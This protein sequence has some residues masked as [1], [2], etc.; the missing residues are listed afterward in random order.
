[1]PAGRVAPQVNRKTVLLEGELIMAT[2]VEAPLAV[3]LVQIPV[4]L[5]QIPVTLVQI[6]AKGKRSIKRYSTVVG[7]GFGVIQ[8]N[9]LLKMKKRTQE[10]ER[11]AKCP[12]RKTEPE[13]E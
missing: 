9:L 12:I 8:A 11:V 6:Q 5:V 3:T 1:V 13:K 10:A 4:T 7:P 2:L